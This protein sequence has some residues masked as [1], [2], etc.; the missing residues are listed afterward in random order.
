MCPF[1]H[2]HVCIFAGVPVCRLGRW[3]REE[4]VMEAMKLASDYMNVI[5]VEF[6]I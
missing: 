3:I 2:I 6:V 4:Y 1:L 5:L